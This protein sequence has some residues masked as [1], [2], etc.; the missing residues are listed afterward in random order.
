MDRSITGFS[1]VGGELF[2]GGELVEFPYSVAKSVRCGCLL[3]VML[4]PPVD[5]DFNRNVYAVNGEGVVVWQIAESPHGGEGSEPYVDISMDRQSRL[6]AANWI[7]I[8][9]FVDVEGGS[10]APASFN[11]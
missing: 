6:L 1:Q 9:Y 10:V 7:G 11:K 4:D 2:V 3:I 5:V 8:D